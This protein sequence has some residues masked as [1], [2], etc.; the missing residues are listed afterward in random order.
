MKIH[1]VFLITALLFSI[2]FLFFNREDDTL[3]INVH[4]TYF[5]IA[6]IHLWIAYTFFLTILSLGYY[7]CYT[8]NLTLNKYLSLS[9]Y[10]LTFIPLIVIPICLKLISDRDNR[11]FRRRYYSELGQVLTCEKVVYYA[12]AFIIIGQIFFI[13]TLATSK[14]A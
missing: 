5:V 13:I 12:I 7:W 11:Y 1:K 4:D 9:H 10:L 6:K 3:D 14:K 8:F 2:C